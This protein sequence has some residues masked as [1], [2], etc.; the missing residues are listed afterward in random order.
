VEEALIVGWRSRSSPFCVNF[1]C[2]EKDNGLTR[3]IR[4]ATVASIV[5]GRN[6]DERRIG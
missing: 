3:R 4:S 2:D 1:E 5:S 6:Q